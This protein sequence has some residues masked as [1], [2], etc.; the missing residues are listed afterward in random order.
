MSNDKPKLLLGMDLRPEFVAL[1]LC[2]DTAGA[3]IEA[4]AQKLIDAE[5]VK[6][7]FL[8][9]ILKR[10][11]EFCTGL[12]FDEMGIAVPHTDPEHVNAPCIGIASLQKPVTFQSMGTP[13]VPC[14]VE[15]LF[16]LGITDPHTQLDFL[17]SLMS[18]FLV[19]GRLTA[20]KATDSPE[21]MVEL[22]ES[23]FE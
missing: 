12:A 2:A 18:S 22:F 15:M 6:P 14:E 23:Y 16:M 20:L 3:A 11:E 19:S 17:Q 5:V 7:S 8:P 9:A 21:R 1:D 13:D 4:L 10:E